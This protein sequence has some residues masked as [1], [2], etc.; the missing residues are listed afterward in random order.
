DAITANYRRIIVLMDGAGDLDPALRARCR[1][2]GRRIFWDKQVA[3]EELARTL[4][5]QP[6]KIR[7]VVDYVA[8]ANLPDAARRPFRVLS[9]NRAPP[10]APSPA[11]KTELDDLHSIQNAYREEVT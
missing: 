7:Q 3:V 11:V 9:E 6:R 5:T 10:P 4:E 2:A 1:T 8:S